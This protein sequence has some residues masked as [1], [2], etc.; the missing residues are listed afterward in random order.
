MWWTIKSFFS[1]TP[2]LWGIIAIA[3]AGMGYGI[4]ANSKNAE[5]L[6]I[7]NELK[8]AVIEDQAIKLDTLNG[9]V[10]DRQERK[11]AWK[12]EAL[13]WKERFNE[14]QDENPTFN[15]CVNTPYPDSLL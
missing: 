6:R 7:E 4:S 9:I 5:R 8:A 11:E 2:V 3:V 15:E 12:Q 13:T 14:A 1:S 10:T